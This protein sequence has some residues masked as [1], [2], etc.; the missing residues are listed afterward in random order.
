MI[1]NKIT[2]IGIGL[3]GSSLA[4]AVRKYNV[5]KEIS[6][7]DILP[8]NVSKALELK[9][10]DD[11]SVNPE[12]VSNADAVFICVPVRSYKNVML[13]IAP[14]LNKNTIISDV[15]SVKYSV[16]KDI[17]DIIPE[18]V[19][20]VPAHPVA[21]TENSGPEAGFAELFLDRWCIVTPLKNNPPD[22][23]LKIINFWQSFGMN[24]EKMDPQHHD[25][26][27]ALVSHIPHL[28]AYSIVGTAANMENSLKKEIIK[29]SASGFRDFT[30]IAGSD[31]K[32]W[33]DIFIANSAFILD[34]LQQFSEDL[35]ELQ[36]AIRKKDENKLFDWFANAKNVRKAIVDAG[37]NVPEDMKKLLCDAK[38]E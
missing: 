1:F 30:R 29:Y 10:V 24:V 17:E 38:G 11:A 7:F 21:G 4:R 26:V 22:A 19:C 15:G 8:Q 25:L 27:M 23:V 34:V 9:I 37:Q 12:I 6:A 16:I 3:I 20:F 18:G 28:I 32:M 5:A 31:P 35:T 14:F 2:I 13:Q 36:K 33:Q